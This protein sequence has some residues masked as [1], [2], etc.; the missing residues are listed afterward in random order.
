LVGLEAVNSNVFKRPLVVSLVNSKIYATKE[1]DRETNVL[2]RIT[3]VFGKFTIPV[4]VFLVRAFRSGKEDIS[5]MSNQEISPVPNQQNIYSLDFLAARPDPGTFNLEFR[6]VP[7]DKTEQFQTVSSAVRRLQVVAAIGL[8]E[9]QLEI[10]EQDRSIVAQSFQ[11]GETIK[12]EFIMKGSQTLS[13]SFRLKNLV[14]TRPVQAHQVFLKFTHQTSQ[15]SKY[16]IVDNNGQTYDVKLINK[17][18][19]QKL[20]NVNG[21]YDME[22]LIGDSFV[23]SSFRW[24]VARISFRFEGKT[25]AGDIQNIYAVLPPINHNFRPA[26]NLAPEILTYIFTVLVMLPFII[27]IA[28]VYR[29]GGI[30][31]SIPGDFTFISAVIFELGI[32]SLFCLI[33]L[34]WFS[35]TL[36]TALS[37]GTLIA[38]PTIFFGKEVLKYNA[39]LRLKKKV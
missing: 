25:V 16:F 22:L 4:K 20:N 24:V 14:N 33:L 26:A 27:F 10:I 30:M 8:S 34:Y 37:Y 1:K 38:V 7:L 17:K 12:S 29:L 13:I 35:L 39:Q 28:S 36:F 18:I 31:N 5:L 15:Q 21:T 9:G 2:V 32:G 19:G 6:V 3:D 11:Q 23:S